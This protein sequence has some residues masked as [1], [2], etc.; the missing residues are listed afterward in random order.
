MDAMI[1]DS[2]W[3]TSSDSSSSSEDQEE[4]DFQYGGQAQSILS[5][6]EESIGK[7][8]DFLSFERTFVH[9]DV[10][11]SVSDPTGPMGRFYH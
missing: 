10:V 1:S 4:I 8:D 5:S 6:L 11:C 9:G 7:I 2:E 3:E